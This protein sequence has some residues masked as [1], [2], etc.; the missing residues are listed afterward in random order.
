MKEL[1]NSLKAVLYSRVSSPIYSTFILAWCVYN[2]EAVLTL[3]FS[4]EALKVRIETCRALF[5][6]DGSFD[7][8]T[9]KW[10]ALTT[11]SFLA[12]KPV[13]ESILYVL[14]ARLHAWAENLRDSFNESRRLT[15]E[16]SQAYVEELNRDRERY[17]NL[18]VERNQEVE[19]LNERAES[20]SQLLDAAKKDIGEEK[21]AHQQTEGKLKRSQVAAAEALAKVQRENESY[22]SFVDFCNCV[23]SC[24]VFNHESYKRSFETHVT[25]YLDSYLSKGMPCMTVLIYG[26]IRSSSY[27]YADYYFDTAFANNLE[28]MKKPE[29]ELLLEVMEDYSQIIGRH[30]N[31][32]DLA[33]VRAVYE[34]Q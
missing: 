30:D 6:T 4:E 27:S 7:W 15:S 1:T 8:Q 33:R 13:A 32:D 21:V 31:V 22:V 10:P 17:N 18:L 34:S 26:F 16:Q 2:W 9:L 12:A 23:L 5:Y 28:K 11:I 14:S 20:M 3:L 24:D 19:S 29:L 25:G